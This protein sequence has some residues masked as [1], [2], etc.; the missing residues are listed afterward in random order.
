MTN[1]HPNSAKIESIEDVRIWAVDRDATS[2]PRWR[3]QWRCN[4]EYEAEM[5]LLN[6]RVSA[7]EGK[8]LWLAG[9]AAALGGLVG[10]LVPKLFG[11]G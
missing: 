11:G 5:N 9:F 1:Q 8:I 2:G 4:D 3:N 10:A 7:M 6:G